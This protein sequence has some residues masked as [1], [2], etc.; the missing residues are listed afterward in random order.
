MRILLWHIHG[1]WMTAFVQG[2]HEY[3]VPMLP[4]RGPDGRGRARTW[5][6]PSSVREVSPDE[7]AREDVDVVLLQRPKE[8]HRLAERW[9]GGRKPGRD[10]TA[11]YLEHNVPLARI[12]DALH[13]AADR[14]DLTLV[15]VTPFNELVWD[16]GST[17]TRVVEHGVI[18]PGYRYSGEMP[19]VVAVVNEARRRGRRTGTDL[20]ERIRRAVPLDLFGMKAS[21][22]GGVEDLPQARLHDEMA[23]RRVYLHPNRWTSLGLSL[24][25]AMHLGMPVVAV[26]AT[27]APRAVPAETG[28]T[29]TSVV[30]LTAA[31]GSLVNDR[32]EAALKGKAARE[33]AL[34]RYGLSRFLSD[35][36]R[37]LEEARAR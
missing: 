12:P 31:L 7:T 6:W 8:L 16:P 22:L 10:V 25:E 9:L 26:A 14:P 32:E 29:S 5:D 34:A 21:Q 36:D 18:D 11:V 15:H 1:S 4:D 3:L 19:R 28:F 13:P 30:E 23:R 27:D 35:W 2:G 24:I 17:P 20:L 37:V 33:W